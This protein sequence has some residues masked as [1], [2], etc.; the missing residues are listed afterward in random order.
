MPDIVGIALIIGNTLLFATPLLYAALGGMLSEKSGVV[1]IG[2]EGMMTIGALV[3]ATVGY[4]T[5]NPWLAFL[6]AGAAGGLLAL[7]HAVVSIT[8]GADQIVSGIAINFLGPGIALFMSR[9][10]FD[11]ATQTKPIAN[12]MPILFKDALANH[13]ALKYIFG[14]YATVYIA[15]FFVL[16]LWIYLYKT[17]YGLRH[18]AVGEHPKAAETLNINVIAIR[19]LAVVASGVMAGFGGASLSL[20]IVSSFRQTLVSGQGF[21]ALVA[22]IFG[23]WTPHG[24]LGACLFFGFAEALAI[25]LGSTNLAISS[26][27][28]SMVPYLS[29]LLI[30]ILFVGRSRG[31]KANGVPYLKDDISL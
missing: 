3:A 18:I 11:G 30:L 12:K 13:P 1:N 5:Q 7:L 31:P 22:L 14:Q 24:I 19:Y 9:L 6:A 28:I 16:I 10:F 21:I 17:K 29:T 2:L 25:F 15:L 20:A 4:Y 27:L 23:K 26:H 8:F